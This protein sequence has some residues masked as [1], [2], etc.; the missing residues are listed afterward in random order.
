MELTKIILLLSIVY[1][2]SCSVPKIKELKCAVCKSLVTELLNEVKKVD[3][4]KKIKVGGY[5][6]AADGNQK[7]VTRSYAGSEGHMTEVFEG[8]C[9]KMKDHV[10]ARD[11]T[12]QDLEII[13]LMGADGKMNVDF[14]AYDLVQ[15]PDLNKGVETQCHSLVEDLEED[16]V[17]AFASVDLQSVKGALLQRNVCSTGAICPPSQVKAEL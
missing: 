8:I 12:T 1:L 11:K 9:E 6:I 14:G 15:D 16:I 4:R 3:P 7:P 5:R 13:A 10:Q 17:T 2:A